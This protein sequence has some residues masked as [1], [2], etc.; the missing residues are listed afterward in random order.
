MQSMETIVNYF[1]KDMRSHGIPVREIRKEST[2]V[3]AIMAAAGFIA[4]MIQLQIL[5]SVI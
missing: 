3:Y 1:A 5:P 4:K 2:I